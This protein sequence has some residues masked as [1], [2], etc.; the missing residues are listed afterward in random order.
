[1]RAVD[2]LIRNAVEATSGNGEVV[3]RSG[4]VEVLEARAGYETIP[5]GRYVTLSVSDDGSGIEPHDLG[6]V[7]EPFFTKKRAKETSGSGLGLAIV[8]GVV[9][10]HDGFI[11][12][13]S[14]P[15]VGTTI[16]LYFPR[17]DGIERRGPARAAP[18]GS[19]RILIVDDE[20]IQLRT[21]RRVLVR[22]GYDVEVLES[23]LAAC[24]L[25]SRAAAAGKSPFDLVIMDMVLGE[26]V[27]G[28]SVIEQI[29]RLFPEQKAI[30]ASGHAPTERAALAV[31]QGL[32]WLAKPYGMETLAQA[33]HRALRRGREPDDEEEGGQAAWARPSVAGS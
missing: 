28:L 32:T 23:G 4:E 3:V 21:C 31:K 10:E 18:R 1:V 15:R 22:L 2:N 11:D 19:A 5:A 7:F 30:M 6:Q 27:D 12:V 8:H 26:V 25:F 13:T 33:V 24:E 16:S 17:V 20:P 9:K 29:R 14:T